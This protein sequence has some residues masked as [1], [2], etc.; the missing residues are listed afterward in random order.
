VGEKTLAL[1]S[2]GATVFRKTQDIASLILFFQTMKI[3]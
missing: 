2:T 3:P 1:L